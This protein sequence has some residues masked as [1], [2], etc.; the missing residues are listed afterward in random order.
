[1]EGSPKNNV[2]NLSE[3]RRQKYEKKKGTIE[4]LIQQYCDS[5]NLPYDINWH[6]PS[7]SNEFKLEILPNAKSK[8]PNYIQDVHK[9]LSHVNGYL[10]DEGYVFHQ[11]LNSLNQNLIV[12]F[13]KEA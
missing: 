12:T 8:N 9:I 1:M 5:Q 3:Y 4:N 7:S 2:V 11:S 6:I 10:S 13:R